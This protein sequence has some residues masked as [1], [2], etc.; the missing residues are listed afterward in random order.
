MNQ[1]LYR[2]VRHRNPQVLPSLVLSA[3]VGGLAW[4]KLE[5]VINPAP[6]LSSYSYEP[7]D[8]VT[9]HP[10]KQIAPNNYKRWSFN[11]KYL[12]GAIAGSL[13]GLLVTQSPLG[14]LTGGAAGLAGGA[15]VFALAFVRLSQDDSW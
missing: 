10:G 4:W 13:T 2:P 3:L 14:I 12:A 6:P 8:P 11:E 15:G 7:N 9:G 5:D 1:S